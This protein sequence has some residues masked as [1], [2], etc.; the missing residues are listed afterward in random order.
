MLNPSMGCLSKEIGFFEEVRRRRIGVIVSPQKKKRRNALRD[1]D[2]PTKRA[3]S[4]DAP[5]NDG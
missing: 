2:R 1:D 3:T 4:L 5:K